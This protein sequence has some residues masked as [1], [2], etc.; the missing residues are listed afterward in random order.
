V[1]L[2]VRNRFAPL[3]SCSLLAICLAYFSALK[4]EPVC[5]SKV[6]HIY[7]YRP[8]RRHIPE[9]SALYSDRCE[10]LKSN[11]IRIRLYYQNAD[12]HD[13]FLHMNVLESPCFCVA[14]FC[15]VSRWAGSL[16]RGTISHQTSKWPSLTEFIHNRN[17]FEDEVRE[18][19]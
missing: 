14:L 5:S 16:I 1:H 2:F 6:L 13:L 10:N 15:K 8:T 18:R 3:A 11:I 19:A 9:E 7:F 17:G 4:M 12:T